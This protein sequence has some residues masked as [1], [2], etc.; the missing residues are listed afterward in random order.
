M[1]V[2]GEGTFAF[3]GGGGYLGGGGAGM[4]AVMPGTE[5]KANMPDAPTAPATGSGGGSANWLVLPG[6]PGGSGGK[7]KG[8]G[9]ERSVVWPGML[10]GGGGGLFM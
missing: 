2:A 5:G 4:L 9:R 3:F 7:G 10:P 8:A 6:C 1:S